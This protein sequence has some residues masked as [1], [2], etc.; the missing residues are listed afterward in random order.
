MLFNGKQKTNDL[1]KAVYW[2]DTIQSYLLKS[3]SPL[4]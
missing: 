3:L 4:R 1:A 2:E